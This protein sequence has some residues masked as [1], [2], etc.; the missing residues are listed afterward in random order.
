MS[1]DCANALAAA[2]RSCSPCGGAVASVTISLGFSSSLPSSSSF[3]D[4]VASNWLTPATVI[5]Y[6]S[7][8]ELKTQ[9]SYLPVCTL[10]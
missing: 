5:A 1:L 8:R 4:N 10:T 7:W 6:N 9:N 2:R 3:T